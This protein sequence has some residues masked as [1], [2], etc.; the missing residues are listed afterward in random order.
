MWDQLR[1]LENSQMENTNRQA[2]PSSHGRYRSFI[3]IFL[4]MILSFGLIIS[5]Y[6]LTE[7]PEDFELNCDDLNT[8]CVNYKYPHFKPSRLAIV[9]VHPENNN[10]ILRSNM[11]LF[12]GAFSEE[13]LRKEIKRLMESSGLA[14]D[15]KMSLNIISFLRNT[16]YEGCCYTIER[17]SVKSDMI[18]NYPILGTSIN[19][20]DVDPKIRNKELAT[21]NWDSDNLIERVTELNNKFN[22]VKNTIFLVHCRHGRDRTGE[23][24]AAYRMLIKRDKFIDVIKANEQMGIGTTNIYIEMEKWLCLYLEKV[25]GFPDVG[26]FDLKYDKQQHPKK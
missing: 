13:M 12:N 22:A 9:D 3:Y 4:A 5:Y 11:P 16:S 26:C 18:T 20:Y 25:M 8:K 23:F 6:A 17:C 24:V 1:D 21:L 14:Y 15:D 7:E 2:T 19:P 10:V